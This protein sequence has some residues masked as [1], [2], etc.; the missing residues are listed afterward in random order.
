MNRTICVDTGCVFGGRLTALRWPER[1][2][3]S[4]PAARTWCEP[5]RPLNHGDADGAGTLDIGDVLGKRIIE[6]RLHRTVTIREDNAAAALETMSRFAADPRWLIYLPPTMPPV[7]ASTRPGILEYPA[8]ALSAI[9]HCVTIGSGN[10]R[11][12]GPWNSSKIFFIFGTTAT[13]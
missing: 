7:P 8:D 10:A 6:T 4:V 9:S 12:L 2:L 11:P 1:Q 5:V 13:A 3:V